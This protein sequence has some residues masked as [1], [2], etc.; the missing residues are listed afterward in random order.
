VPD[1]RG[2]YQRAQESQAKKER[3]KPMHLYTRKENS[4]RHS[5]LYVGLDG[6]VDKQEGGTKGGTQRT[7]MLPAALGPY[8]AM[9][10]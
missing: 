9:L 2:N 3:E 4:R 10:R 5:Q 8:K 7:T 6:E 1:S